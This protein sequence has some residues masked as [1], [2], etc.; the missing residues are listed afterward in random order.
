MIASGQFHGICRSLGSLVICAF[1]G[2]NCQ[3]RPNAV[4]ILLNLFNPAI[5]EH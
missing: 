4:I 1:A 3:I 5:E 2:Q